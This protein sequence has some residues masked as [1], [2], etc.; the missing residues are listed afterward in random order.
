M[1]P[2][3]NNRNI[4]S[5]NFLGGND[6]MLGESSPGEEAGEQKG[7]LVYDMALVTLPWWTFRQMALKDE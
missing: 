1:L 7:W 3:S 5:Q 6:L 2:L 4:L